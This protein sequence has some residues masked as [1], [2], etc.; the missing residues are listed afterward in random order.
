[1]YKPFLYAK[2][3]KDKKSNHYY[4]YF[5][6]ENVKMKTKSMSNLHNL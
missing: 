1:M 4:I 5:V 3:K 2:I 6:K